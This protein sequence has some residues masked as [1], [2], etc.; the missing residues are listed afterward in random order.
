MNASLTLDAQPVALVFLAAAVAAAI[1]AYA[2]RY[3]VLPPRRRAILL[4]TRAL[5]LAA[6]VVASLA[7]VARVPSASK[8]RNRLL[9]LV[10]H[11]GSMEV[12]DAPGGRTRREAADSAAASVGSLVGGRLDV[13]VAPFDAEL[14][15]FRRDAASLGGGAALHG[16]TA[17]GDALRSALARVDPDSVA[18]ILIVSDGAVNRGEDPERALDASIPTF[19]LAVGSPSD[20]PTVGIAGVEAPSEAVVGRPAAI[21]VTIRQGAR[22]ESRGVARLAEGGRELGRA[23]FALEGPG[24]TSRIVIPFTSSEPG[25][26]FLAIRLD[27]I[28]GDP[29]RENKERLIAIEVRPARRRVAM[30]APAWDWDLRSLARGVEADTSWAVERLAPAGSDGATPLGASTAS[31]ASFLDG[32]EAAVVRYDARD[33]TPERAAALERYL[34]RGGGA[35][36]W[37]D[38]NGHAPPETPLGKALGLTWRFWGDDPGA[39]A[40]AELAP[41]GKTHDVTLLGGDA[42]SAAAVWRDLPP[43]RPPVLLGAQGGTLTPILNGRLSAGTA[44]LLLAG[45]LGAGRVAVLNAAGVYRW[46][47]TAAGLGDEA[48]VE[49][50]FFGGLVRWLASA[51]EDRPVHLTAPDITPEGRAIALRLTSSAPVDPG[52]RATVRAR[53]VAGAPAPAAAAA[54]A[55]RDTT[56]TA[57]GAGAFVGS[58]VLPPGT[59]VL[60]GRLERDGRRVGED[61]VRVAV[62][63][64]GI[65]FESL[66]A[67]PDI[68]ERVTGRSGGASAPLGAPAPVLDRLRAPDLARS[69]LAEIDLFHNPYLFAVIVIGLALE[70]ALRRRF[71]LM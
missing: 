59:Y 53:R 20:P 66:A 41:A 2:T 46:G 65:E 6:V 28:A 56:L 26:H 42:A 17:L 57:E 23:P 10:D 39:T 5:T 43:V 58:L 27:E 60:S 48:G 29:M 36:L 31:Y 63:A 14:A 45:H 19:A 13:R 7:P 8:E 18:A 11:S 21:T 70:W 52:A 9:V 69:R 34:E 22:R 51:E 12:R 47:L 49:A 32:A 44:P 25:K 35:L 38:P 4:W 16:E 15:P 40:T 54:A 37:I 67:E 3:P 50:T 68:L 24:A 55:R 64:Q 30:L 1:W 71:H 62:G 61:S 33:I